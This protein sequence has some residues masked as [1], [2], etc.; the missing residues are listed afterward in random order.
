MPGRPFHREN[1]WRIGTNRPWEPPITGAYPSVL[2]Q[3]SIA[4]PKTSTGQSIR[5]GPRR[6]ITVIVRPGTTTSTISN[7]T[8]TAEAVGQSRLAK[9]SSHNTLPI[10]C[11]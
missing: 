11:D 5:G 6:L 7:H 2:G 9:N 4:L 3:A 8:A 10:N 1:D